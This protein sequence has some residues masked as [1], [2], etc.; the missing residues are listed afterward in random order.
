MFAEAEVR[1]VI[2]PDGAVDY[3][4]RA[5]D[6]LSM[7]VYPGLGLAGGTVRFVDME[8][9]ALDEEGVSIPFLRGGAKVYLSRSGHLGFVYSREGILTVIDT[10]T[11]RVIRQI[12]L[13]GICSGC[14]VEV[15]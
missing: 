4:L 15:Y 6:D 10:E 7:I 2:L 12:S 14:A 1:T 11:K 13:P 9:L 3:D 8:R 5:S